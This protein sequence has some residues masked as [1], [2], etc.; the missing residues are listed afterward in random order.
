[1]N[2]VVNPFTLESATVGIA[3]NA[4][5]MTLSML[6]VTLILLTIWVDES[7]LAVHLALFHGARV[8]LLARTE[9]KCVNGLRTVLAS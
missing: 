2:L 5:P 8:K 4:I 9:R 1:M 6:E 3:V 7:T